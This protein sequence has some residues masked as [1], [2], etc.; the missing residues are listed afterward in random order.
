V[1]DNEIDAAGLIR[2]SY[3]IEGF[4]AS[5]C[6]SIFMDWLLKLP[7]SVPPREAIAQLLVR[8]AS[9][10]ADHPMTTV[11]RAGLDPSARPV[12]R[13]GHRARTRGAAK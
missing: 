4:S 3:R 11:L 9:V 8:H 2:E 10:H 6:R 12:R 5:Q 13:G 1:S 7:Q